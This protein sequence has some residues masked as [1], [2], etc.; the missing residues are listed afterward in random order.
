MENLGNEWKNKILRGIE[1]LKEKIKKA[2]NE[3][4]LLSLS[5]EVYGN[6][7][8]YKQHREG[9]GVA[10]LVIKKNENS[11]NFFYMKTEW[12]GNSDYGEN[13]IDIPTAFSFKELKESLITVIDE[14]YYQCAI[15][16]FSD[17]EEEEYEDE[18]EGT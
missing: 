11:K 15:E 2:K 13:R 5:C 16:Y 14:H 9:N 8:N 12:S 7:E 10:F 6:E 1:K 17:D 3:Q 4:E 18:G